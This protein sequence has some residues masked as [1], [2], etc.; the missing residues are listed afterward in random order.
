MGQKSPAGC[1]D[2]SRPEADM[3]KGIRHSHI[4]S[5]PQ[6]QAARQAQPTAAQIRRGNDLLSPNRMT[7][8]P[9][10]GGCPEPG[11]GQTDGYLNAG[12]SHW[13]VCSQ[14]QTRWCAG[15]NL[16]SDWKDE[17]EDQQPQAFALIEHF[18]EVS[19]S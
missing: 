3:E 5:R 9:C 8:K 15:T 7:G 13:F 14:H 2:G 11:C 16:F 18:R 12:A 10:F 19:P 17:S 4:G 6:R 1:D